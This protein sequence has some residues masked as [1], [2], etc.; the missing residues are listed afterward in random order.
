MAPDDHVGN[1]KIPTIP[2][3]DSQHATCN[4]VMLVVNGNARVVHD[5]PVY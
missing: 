4:S 5:A 3:S 1:V 2:N